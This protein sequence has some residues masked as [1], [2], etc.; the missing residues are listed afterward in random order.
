MKQIEDATTEASEQHFQQG[1]GST[2]TGNPACGTPPLA[3]MWMRNSKTARRSALCAGRPLASFQRYAAG[4]RE[5]HV[6]QARQPNRAALAGYGQAGGTIQKHLRPLAMDLDF[7][8]LIPNCPWLAAWGWLK[9]VFARAERI[10]QRPLREIPPNSI[11]D[12]LRT[13]LLEFDAHDADGN[14]R[15][16]QTGA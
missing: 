8:S 1:A 6:L 9:K 5:A 12:R 14:L 11:P 16:R 13:Y 3:F 4:C 7:S 2:A 15:I 10:A